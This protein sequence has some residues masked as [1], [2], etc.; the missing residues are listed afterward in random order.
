MKAAVFVTG[1]YDKY[2]CVPLLEQITQQAETEIFIHVWEFKSGWYRKRIQF[3]LEN[4][5][6]LHATLHVVNTNYE[7]LLGEWKHLASLFVDANGYQADVGYISMFYSMHRLRDAFETYTKSKN[8]N[9][10][11]V[12]SCKFNTVTNETFNFGNLDYRKIYLP[13]NCE[14]PVNDIFAI[15][16]QKNMQHYMNVYNNL[17]SYASNVNSI[18]SVMSHHLKHLEKN[19]IMMIV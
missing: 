10:D 6:K 19:K 11:F 8:K 18:N 14:S 15:S 9:M 17:Q 13:D 2:F 7:R 16:N 5:K 3:D 1:I 4:F 12:V